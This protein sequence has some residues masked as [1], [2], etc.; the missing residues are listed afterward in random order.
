MAKTVCACVAKV[1]AVAVL[2]ALTCGCCRTEPPIRDVAAL[3]GGYL[4]LPEFRLNDPNCR[5]SYRTCQQCYLSGC[6]REQVIRYLK[7]SVATLWSARS[8]RQSSNVM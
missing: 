4:G 6:V 5:L 8:Y 1:L 2:C 7:T 3:N